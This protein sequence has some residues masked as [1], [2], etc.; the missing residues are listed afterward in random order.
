MKVKKGH[1]ADDGGD[2]F[3]ANVYIHNRKYSRTIG[4]GE[5]SEG[6]WRCHIS[7]GREKLNP[8]PLRN[9]N[10]DDHRGRIL[11]IFQNENNTQ[12]DHCRRPQSN[13]AA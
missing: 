2:K 12:S 9:N 10:T 11:R 1:T 13:D 5:I 7:R 8:I 6:R 4:S 3:M